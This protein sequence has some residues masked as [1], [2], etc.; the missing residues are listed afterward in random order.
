MLYF[1]YFI[2]D[3]FV[4]NNFKNKKKILVFRLAF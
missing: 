3:E 4:T 2:D 1:Y